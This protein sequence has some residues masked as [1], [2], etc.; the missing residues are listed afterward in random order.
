VVKQAQDHPAGIW[1]K[2]PA[3]WRS[4][5]TAATCSRV[6]VRKW[7]PVINQTANW[8][9]RS[10]DLPFFL[11]YHLLL[12]VDVGITMV[13]LNIFTGNFPEFDLRANQVVGDARP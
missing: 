10:S 2:H 7:L 13:E 4:L 8:I 1:P 11:G 6:S 5:R 3:P 9:D 12:P